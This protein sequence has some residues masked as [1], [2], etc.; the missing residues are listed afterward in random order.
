MRCITKFIMAF[1]R[2]RFTIEAIVRNGCLPDRRTG[3][4]KI[5]MLV[6]DLHECDSRTAL[7]LQRAMMTSQEEA[8]IALVK[9]FYDYIGKGDRDGAY[10][11]IFAEDGELH[12]SAMLP[13]GGVYRGRDNVKD[14]LARVMSGFDAVECD[15]RNYLA[16][17][18]EVVVHLHLKG[19]GRESR[20]PFAVTIMELWRFRAGRAVELRPFLFD[21]SVIADALA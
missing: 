8:N 13:Y 11:N 12:E 17:G 15:I 7:H 5:R 19:V 21:P 20:M 14:T 10:A 9:K 3:T 4:G 2:Q 6:R 16:G 1:K 18:D